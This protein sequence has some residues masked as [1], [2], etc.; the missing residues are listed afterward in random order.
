MIFSVEYKHGEPPSNKEKVIVL[1]EFRTV[2]QVGTR[3]LVP[4]TSST[5]CATR[6]L[7]TD[8]SGAED[9]W[10]AAQQARVPPEGGNV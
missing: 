7:K 4:L 8:T 9:K 2:I 6:R 5:L 3:R 1:H 10:V